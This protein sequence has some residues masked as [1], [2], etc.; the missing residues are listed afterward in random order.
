MSS[1]EVSLMSVH[2]FVQRFVFSIIQNIKAKNFKYEEKVVVDA[3]LVPRVSEN[4]MMASLG[5][6]MSPGNRKFGYIVRKKMDIRKRDMSELV[7]PINLDKPVKRNLDLNKH[8][9]RS[10]GIPQ[11]LTPVHRINSPIRDVPTPGA[12]EVKMKA[13][14]GEMVL[15][16]DYGKIVPL[17]NDPSVSSIECP[18][19]DKPLFVIRV[20]QKQITK[21]TLNVL[22]IKALLEKFAD[23]AHIPLLEGLF[24]VSVDGMNIN[25]VVSEILG[26]KFVIKKDTAYGLL[27]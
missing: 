7:A 8:M 10:A 3:D 12:P 23:V 9:E 5:E 13:P 22:E 27:E 26:S 4:V 14:Q 16:H 6:K 2:P 11:G 25:A 24:R 1:D 15:S 21:I 18:G 20:G 19:P 17:L